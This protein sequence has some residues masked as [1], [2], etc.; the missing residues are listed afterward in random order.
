L[1]RPTYLI[2]LTLSIGRLNPKDSNAV[3]QLVEIIARVF[4]VE[5]GAVAITM[6]PTEYRS[7]EA[8]VMIEKND[9]TEARFS[10]FDRVQAQKMFD[11]NNYGG[12]QSPLPPFHPVAPFAW[13]WGGNGF[14]HRVVPM[15]PCPPFC[16]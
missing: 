8:E 3:Q 14:M 5:R 13:G 6:G 15:I 1:T 10:N 12:T 4:A 9:Q 2:T 7:L 11:D 16:V